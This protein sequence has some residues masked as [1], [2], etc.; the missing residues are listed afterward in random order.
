M[1]DTLDLTIVYEPAG[2]GWVIA[3]IPELPGVHSQGE[4]REQARTNVLSALQDWLRFY[5]DDQRAAM[6]LPPDADTEPVHVTL[7][8]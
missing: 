5:V 2:D 1:G 6:E 8:A 4:N 7:A 3:S